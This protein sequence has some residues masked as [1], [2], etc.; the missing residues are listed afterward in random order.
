MKKKEL[1]INEIFCGMPHLKKYFQ[2]QERLIK[3]FGEGNT[4]NVTV[5]ELKQKELGL[6]KTV[7]EMDIE[8]LWVVQY[9]HNIQKLKPY[10]VVELLRETNQAVEELLSL[11][12]EI[13]KENDK[14]P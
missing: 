9:V 7:R 14:M 13:K 2:A 4:E 11:S 3:K 10:R 8:D 5:K 6:L 1:T 12:K